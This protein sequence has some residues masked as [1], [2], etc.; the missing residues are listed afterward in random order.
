M[1][2]L[3][4]TW[5]GSN[6]LTTL[7]D[8]FVVYLLSWRRHPVIVLTDTQLK[9]MKNLT[10]KGVRRSELQTLT[11]IKWTTLYDNL[12]KLRQWGMIK[13]TSEERKVSGRPRIYWHRL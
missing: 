6:T 7:R 1:S 4:E 12:V 2:N 3:Q 10:L 8:E 9:I 11:G 5:M 13:R